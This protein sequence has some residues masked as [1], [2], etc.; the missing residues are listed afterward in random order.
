MKKI[1]FAGMVLAVGT[2]NAFANCDSNTKVQASVLAGQ[3]V[4]ASSSGE[5]WKESHCGSGTSGELWKVG[6]GTAVDPAV[7]IG[8]WSTKAH[9]V[10]YDYGTGGAYT[11]TLHKVGTT[12]FFCNGN[13]EVAS[14]TLGSL[15]DCSA[16]ASASAPAP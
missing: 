2:V 16:P 1:M 9:D 7:K 14:G 6:A 13:S 3:S 4:D 8:T 10:T 15:G 11:W 5:N 12:Y